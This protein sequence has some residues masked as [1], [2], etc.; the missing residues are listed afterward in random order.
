MT[1]LAFELLRT[2]IMAGVFLHLFFVGRK[3]N[4]HTHAGW[5]HIILGF[6]LLVFG[7]SVDILND[8]PLLKRYVFYDNN[9]YY[10]FFENIVGYLAG[11]V[12][13]AIGFYKWIPSVAASNRVNQIL[14]KYSDELE[15]NVTLRTIELNDVIDQLQKEVK[16]RQNA[17]Q[18]IEESKELYSNIVESM[19]DGI[20]VLNRDFQ[21]THWN[22]AMEKIS[23]ASRSNIINSDR[24]PW[25][26][27]PY[28][29]EQGVDH[30]MQRAMRGEIAQRDDIPFRLGDGTRGF[31]S[32]IFLPLR[33]EN[34]EI[35]GMV[36]IV[37]DV[38][39]KKELEAH[40]QRA[41]KMEAIAEMAGGIAHDFNNMLTSVV[42]YISLAIM[43]LKAGRNAW[44]ELET[45][46]HTVMRSS[47]LA[48]KL[49]TFS[50]GNKPVKNSV[51]IV[52]LVNRSSE[53]A[54]SG[55]NIAFEF[56]TPDDGLMVNID[57]NQI[58]QAIYNII[59]N[60][61]ESM[62]HGGK[63]KIKARN[64]HASP[65]NRLDLAEGDYVKISVSDDGPG[66]PQHYLEKIFDPYFSTKK[67]GTQKG[68][69]LGLSI[70]HSII[71]KHHGNLAV[72]S[73]LGKGTTFLILLPAA[74]VEHGEVAQINI[75]AKPE[76]VVAG[77]KPQRIIIM[78]DEAL[79]LE[80]S[81]RML[82]HLGY[83]SEFAENGDQAIIIYKQALGS[84]RTFDAVILD[85]TVKGG[86]GAEE[87]IKEL[88]KIDPSAVA[89]ISSGYSNDPLMIDY[90]KYG[91][92]G[93]IVKPYDMGNLESV[94]SLIGPMQQ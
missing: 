5:Y 2:I 24:K 34:G 29:R 93:A 45:A 83:E 87:T 33:A 73:E 8:I 88:L 23:K 21:Y 39:E 58:A 63:I 20:F 41:Q 74:D 40:L 59:I 7:M 53:L 31:T 30:M 56:L 35:R 79:L 81:G 71:K 16:E 67:R 94:M 91:F 18:V 26:L 42:G 64:Y 55:S 32:D 12:M 50:R 80:V 51:C 28:F 85:L 22:R 6:A 4:I 11:F 17:E 69:G 90:E 61:K 54:L 47:E 57:E 70:T 66:I 60:A 76:D 52:D 43:N 13:L 89:F 27:F 44:K 68:M 77:G 46:E 10:A 25:E 9:L 38:T 62:Q 19:S 37:R 84:G 1:E 82:N 86:M 15:L 48:H 78:D 92:R 36:G 49:I 14:K 65:K 72:V 75:S 3:E